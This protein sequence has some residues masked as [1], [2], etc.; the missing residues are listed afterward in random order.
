MV[1]ASSAVLAVGVAAC[2][3][4]DD[5]G[6]GGGG[7]GGGGASGTIAIDGSST[8]GP[9]TQ[10]VA[11]KFKSENP[12]VN[13]TVGQSGTGGGFEKFCAGETD[14]ND[15]SRAIEPEEVAACKKKGIAY[16][17][18]Q[19]ANDALTV[20]VNPANPNDCLSVDQLASIWGPKNP[21]SS[22]AD[23][24]G[25]DSSFDA[26]VQRFGPGTTSGTFDY[27]TDAINGEEGVQTKDYNNVGE[28]DNQTV[29]GVEGSEGGI[30]Y[31]GFSYYE[32]NAQN[33]KA[34]Q[35]ENDKGKCVEPSSET[36]QDGSYNPL[37][38]PLFI[39]PSDAALKKP[40]VKSFVDYYVNN[41][42]DIVESVGF[43]PMT[44]AQLSKAQ[45]A[46]KGLAG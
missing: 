40:V 8:V 12:G 29:T 2:G 4:D 13:I 31:F 17:E 45:S 25:A 41:V 11:E 18:T 27:F 10:A 36:V 7:G 20:V 38:R 16:G 3:S 5:N 26:D 1:L 15:A 32:E 46:V 42:N 28:D 22:W 14:I 43:I 34:L 44:S 9:L 19:V 24:K 23:V 30:G 35:I 6:S 21:A 33:L 37:G 39:Y